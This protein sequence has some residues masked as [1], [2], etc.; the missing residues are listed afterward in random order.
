MNILTGISID[1]N[2]RWLLIRE[3][4]DEKGRKFTTSL[5][6]PPTK[7]DRIDIITDKDLGEGYRCDVDAIVIVIIKG[8]INSI[9]FK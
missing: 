2:H 5:A 4:I 6:I 8:K 1:P 3:G 9:Y 7:G